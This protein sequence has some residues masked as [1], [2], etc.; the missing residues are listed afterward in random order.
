MELGKK[1]YKTSMLNIFRLMVFG[2]FLFF[3]NDFY[4]ETFTYENFQLDGRFKIVDVLEYHYRYPYR[5]ILFFIFVIIPTFYYMFIRGIRFYE[6][7]LIYNRGLPFLQ[8][9]ILYQELAYYRLLHPDHAISLHTKKGDIFVVA[10]NKIERVIAILDQQ[11]IRGDLTQDDYVKLITNYKKFVMVIVS[12]TIVM[13][14]VKKLGLI[15]I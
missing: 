5:F 10:N 3:L 7:G 12:V 11:N 6:N 9:K 1:I 15:T 4:L 14:V 2:V 13:F 8:T